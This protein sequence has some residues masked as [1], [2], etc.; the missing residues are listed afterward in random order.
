M[1]IQMIDSRN[2]ITNNNTKQENSNTLLVKTN[3]EIRPILQIRTQICWL[4]NCYQ[5]QKKKS[6]V[7]VDGKC[8]LS[9]EDTSSK[10]CL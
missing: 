6:R 8:N 4:V 7:A 1:L 5:W 10:I 2:Y 9:K 3:S